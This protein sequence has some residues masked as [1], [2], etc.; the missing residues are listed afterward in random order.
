MASTYSADLRIELIGAGEQAGTWGSTT[1]TNLGTL[2]EDAIAGAVT[3]AVAATPRALTALNGAVDEARQATLIL[4]TSTGAAFTVYAPPV[5]KQYVIYNNTAFI[6][7]IGNATVVNGVISTGGTTVAIP[8][9]RT[10]TVWSDGTNISSQNTHLPGAPTA[11]TAGP[12][13]N[14]TQIA[15]TAFVTNVAGALGTMSSQNANAV[16]ITGGSI[17]GVTVSG[18]IVGAYPVGSIYMNAANAT[19]PATLLGFGTWTALGAGRMLMGTGG[20][21]GIG[22]TGGSNDAV[23]PSHS[24]SASTSVSVS[25]SDPGHIHTT[26]GYGSGNSATYGNGGGVG[27]TNNST[28]AAVTGVSASATGSTTVSAAGVSATNA[29]LPPYLVVYMWQRTA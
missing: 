20:A 22:T 24:H 8:A 5:S 26:F 1:N 21:F 13:T 16:S 12:G 27:Q 3:V 4:T 15:T 23:V 18:A 10:V 7:T 11:A 17:S 14:T 2:V 28:A 29:N 25:V 9:G 19:N 6:A